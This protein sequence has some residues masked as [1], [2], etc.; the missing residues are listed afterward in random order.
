[1]LKWNELNNFLYYVKRNTHHPS[2]ATRTIGTFVRFTFIWGFHL[3]YFFSGLI[4]LE[5]LLN[6]ILKK[7]TLCGVLQPAYPVLKSCPEA[8]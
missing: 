5:T 6:I 8:R 3:R 2:K 4:L 7:W 1:M